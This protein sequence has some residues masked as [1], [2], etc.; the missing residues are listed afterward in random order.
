[1]NESVNIMAY[2]WI[3]NSLTGFSIMKQWFRAQGDSVATHK[4]FSKSEYIR[5]LLLI[6]WN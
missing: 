3:L 2:L 6:Q 5:M 4:C 1:M